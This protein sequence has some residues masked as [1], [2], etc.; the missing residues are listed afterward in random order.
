MI[1]RPVIVRYHTH[2]LFLNRRH[3]F[4]AVIENRRVHIF[5]QKKIK[6]GICTDLQFQ[7]GSRDKYISVCNISKRLHQQSSGNV[8][9]QILFVFSCHQ[10]FIVRHKTHRRTAN[11]LSLYLYQPVLNRIGTGMVHSLL[12]GSLI[13]VIQK[14]R[15]FPVCFI[16][17]IRSVLCQFL[18]QLFIGNTSFFHC[19]LNIRS[20]IGDVICRFQQ[21]GQ[22]MTSSMSPRAFLY[23]PENV[24]V[25]QKIPHLLCPDIPAFLIDL[26][27]RYRIF[28]DGP[29]QRF[30]QIHP[31]GI[32]QIM[33]FGHQ[34]QRLC[35]P[36]KMIKIRLHLRC[37]NLGQGS[38][39]PLQKRHMNPEPVPNRRLSKMPE[40][41]IADIV[42]K[43]RTLKNVAHIGKT[44]VLSCSLRKDAL[45][46]IRW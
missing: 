20:F 33:Q 1:D 28:D 27:R 21:K 9:K 3:R 10:R 17:N 4:P 24:F 13:T 35:I 39:F 43:P 19:I 2:Q 45:P 14:R 15:P 40:G 36:L 37:Q 41:R 26:Q 29:K 8:V 44:C 25:C 38:P 23:L 5:F 34:T 12:T 30:R 16:L 6:N 46:M 42:Q 7:N 32:H 31:V 11:H 22:R 18:A